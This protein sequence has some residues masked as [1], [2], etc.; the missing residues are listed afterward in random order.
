MLKSDKNYHEGNF[1]FYEYQNTP[2]SNL[3]DLIFAIVILEIITFKMAELNNTKL[4]LSEI[5]STRLFQVMV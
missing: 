2:Q 1:N 5:K 3:D 4:Y